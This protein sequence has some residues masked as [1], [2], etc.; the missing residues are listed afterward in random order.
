MFEHA[1]RHTKR[2]MY[3]KGIL[4]TWPRS[5]RKSFNVYRWGWDVRA[6]LASH[7]GCMFRV[8]HGDIHGHTTDFKLS[9]LN[10]SREESHPS[11]PSKNNVEK[12]S[13]TWWYLFSLTNRSNKISLYIVISNRRWLHRVRWGNRSIMKYND[14]KD[15]VQPLFPMLDYTAIAIDRDVID[16]V[17]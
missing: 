1:S 15:R 7:K 9:I 10:I 11:R 17:G 8:P 12:S 16:V 6:T 3:V 5:S 4:V 2:F 13:S 14:R